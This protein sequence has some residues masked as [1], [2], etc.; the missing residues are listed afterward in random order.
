MKRGVRTAVIAVGSVVATLGVQAAIGQNPA[1]KFTFNGNASA[2][3]QFV[4]ENA[5]YTRDG[6]SYGVLPGAAVNMVVPSGTQAYIHADFSASSL[7]QGPLRCHLRLVIKG[8]GTGGSFISM[9]PQ[10]S[11]VTDFFDSAAVEDWERHSTAGIAGPLNAGTYTVRVEWK[12]AV[13]GA[14]FSL[15]QWLLHVERIT[16]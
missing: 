10:G 9:H 8:P 6:T 5:F 14:Q 11:V 12:V 3:N 15:Q 13:D 16:I 2:K 1:V 7:C 4:S